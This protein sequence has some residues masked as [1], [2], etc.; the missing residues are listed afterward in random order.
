MPNA[1]PHFINTRLPFASVRRAIENFLLLVGTGLFTNLRLSWGF[2]CL[3]PCPYWG[4]R[5]EFPSDWGTH[6]ACWLATDWTVLDIKK[7]GRD[8]EHNCQVVNSG[9]RE[10]AGQVPQHRREE[11]I[12]EQ[13]IKKSALEYQY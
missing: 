1:K 6:L 11:G 3:P 8:V 7:A 9:I 10:N 12:E 13:G 5:P 4:R 2:I